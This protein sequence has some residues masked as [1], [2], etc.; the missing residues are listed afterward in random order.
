VCVC[1]C[2]CVCLVE[3][4]AEADDAHKALEINAKLSHDLQQCTDPVRATSLR[5]T[6]KTAATVESNS[7]TFFFYIYLFLDLFCM[8]LTSRSFVGV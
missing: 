5:E 6:V 1:V 7:V 2:V 3:G 8:F 4:A